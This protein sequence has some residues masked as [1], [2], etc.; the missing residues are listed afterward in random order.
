MHQELQALDQ[1]KTW[2]I[3]PLPPCKRPIACKWVYK[4]KCKADGSIER[5]KVRL[6]VKGF[7]QREGIDYNE[8]F[9]VVVKMTTVRTLMTMVVKKGWFIHQLDVNNV[10]LHGDLHEEI[11][12]N[13]P[14]GICS[15]IPNAVYRSRKSLYGLKQ[16]SRQWYARLSQVLYQRGYSHSKNDYSLFYKKSTNFV[17]FLAV[18]VD[19]ILLTGMMS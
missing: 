13:L 16:A 9:S 17:V 8:T 3:V 6:V 15:F 11:Y 14:Q 19:D 12:M 2:E 5:L 18:Y 10:F 7:T 1:T 4:V